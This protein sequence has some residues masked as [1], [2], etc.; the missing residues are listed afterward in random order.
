MS[1]RLRRF[2]PLLKF[3]ANASPEVQRTVLR[4]HDPALMRCLCECAKNVLNGNVPLTPAQKA[5][6]RPY[7]TGLRTLVKKKAPLYRKHTVVQKGGFL[8]ALLAPIAASVIPSI[9]GG[10]LGKR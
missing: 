1:L 2:A 6:L 4:G 3:L 10:L 8:P 9:L 5:R 7:K